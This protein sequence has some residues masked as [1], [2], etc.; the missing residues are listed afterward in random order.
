MASA[1]ALAALL[2]LLLCGTVRRS[3]ALRHPSQPFRGPIL[4]WNNTPLMFNATATAFSV[5]GWWERFS[6]GLKGGGGG[7]SGGLNNAEEELALKVIPNSELN[8]TLQQALELR[9]KTA[10]QIAKDGWKLVH[11]SDLF[12][13]YKRRSPQGPVEYLMT[14]KIADV[15]P[16]TFLHSQ[17]N[18]DC[19][20]AWDKTMKEM[21]AGSLKLIEGVEGSE[22][23]LYY[24]TKW[25]WPLK[26]R[27]YTLA[28]RCRAYEDKKA[29]VFVSRSASEMD[30]VHNRKEGVIRVDNYWCHSALFSGGIGGVTASSGSGGQ[31][32]GALLAQAKDKDA[33]AKGPFNLFRGAGNGGEGGGEGGKKGDQV[34]CLDQPGMS[35]VSVFCDDQK[36]PLHPRIVDM[37]AHQVG[38]ACVGCVD[39]Y[40]SQ[41]FN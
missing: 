3:N 4:V 8:D 25:P 30:A 28:R 13:L 15:S 37:I 17:I 31:R 34:S 24:R 6:G 9:F 41:I 1:W 23:C 16:R 19:R 22:D 40:S 32:A 29:L 11:K 39:G 27:D 10:E 18:C 35:F 36:V 21:S 2:L 26:D 12:S 38:F 20:R 5:Q 7:G 14:G 33:A